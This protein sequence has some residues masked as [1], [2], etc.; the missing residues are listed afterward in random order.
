M[1]RKFNVKSW[2]DKALGSVLPYLHF[3]LGRGDR[4]HRQVSTTAANHF[5]LMLDNHINPLYPWEQ[6]R[7][8]TNLLLQKEGSL[9]LEQKDNILA[10]LIRKHDAKYVALAACGHYLSTQ[11]LIQLLR[12]ELLVSAQKSD[13]NDLT[14][15]LKMILIASHVNSGISAWEVQCARLLL[16]AGCTSP[17]Q[18]LVASIQVLLA[19][20]PTESLLY[21]HVLKLARKA[22]VIFVA[23]LKLLEIN[24]KWTRALSAVQWLSMFASNVVPKKVLA[25]LC[26][27][28]PSW[29]AWALWQPDMKRILSWDSFTDVQK[30]ALGKI[31][32]LEGPD[33]LR[34]LDSSLREAVSR[35]GLQRPAH[36]PRVSSLI[37]LKGVPVDQIEA[38][39]ERLLKLID[40]VCTNCP[41]NT[42]ILAYF[43][44]G[45]TITNTSLELL[46]YLN[47]VADASISVS[48]SFFSNL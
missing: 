22:L 10:S 12:N 41:Y 30:A 28:F 42:P 31:L 36:I 9:T 14:S 47:S 20:R 27:V 25:L 39:V 29:R 26:D 24:Y 32:T 13:R 16:S 3:N 46:E 33:F 4:W 44:V 1:D 21:L 34:S 23:D 18:S 17:V 35:Q 11:T 15:Y 6:L 45:K 43:C 48:I 8:H 19:G 40:V 2:P 38:S 5:P 37:E 7:E